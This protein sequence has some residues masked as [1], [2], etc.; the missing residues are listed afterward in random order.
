VTA[1]LRWTRTLEALGGVLRGEQS[2]DVLLERRRAAGRAATAPFARPKIVI[3]DRLSD[4]YTVVEVKCPDRPGLLYLIT[5]TLSALE[6]DIASARIATEI[7]QALD[8]FYVHDRK[9]GKVEDPGALHAALEQALV[10]PL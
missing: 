3:D 5:K 8:T 4:D 7:D 2:V 6:L 1:P 9:G 10:Q